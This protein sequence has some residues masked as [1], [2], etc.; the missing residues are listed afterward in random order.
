MRADQRDRPGILLGVAGEGGVAGQLDALHL[1][2]LHFVVIAILGFGY[3]C[4]GIELGMTNVLATVL[5]APGSTTA[6]ADLSLI[7]GALFVGGAFGA[8]MAG[9]LADRYGRKWVLVTAALGFGLASAIAAVAQGPLQLAAARLASGIALAAYLPILWTYLAET[10]PARARGTIMMGLGACGGLGVILAPALSRYFDL[11]PVFGLEGWRVALAAGGL[12]GAAVGCLSMFIP[13]SP[14][15]IEGRG[16]LFDAEHEAE[17]FT[18][19]PPVIRLAPPKRVPLQTP[20]PA[21]ADASDY[22]RFKGRLA[23]LLT[24][25]VIQPVVL[26]GLTALSG[27]V[28]GQKGFSV[29][30]SLLYISLAAFGA[31]VGTLLA[32]AIVDRVSRPSLFIT[33]AV[34]LAILSFAFP[35]VQSAA[36]NVAIAAGFF[37]VVAVYANVLNIYGPEMFESDRRGFATGLGYGLNRAGALLVSFGLLPL[38]MASSALPAFGVISGSLILSATLVFLWGPRDTAGKGLT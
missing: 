23:L 28:L 20:E 10:I 9:R 33:C 34:T 3:L 8:V 11:Y 35:F 22:P 5:G 37:L 13:E 6:H 27:I 17:R 29:N 15:W 30:D 7:L 4:D 19:S 32:A 26:Y 2:R 12:G 31:P 21:S 18:L 38:L 16:R 25:Q 14:R 36:M 24:L 1:T